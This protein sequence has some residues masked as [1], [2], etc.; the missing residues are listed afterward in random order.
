M[1]TALSIPRRVIAALAFL[2]LAP[3]GCNIAGPASFLVMGPEKVSKVFELNSEKRT[4]VFVDNR[5]SKLPNRAVHREVSETAER[6]LL[7]EGHLKTVISS[8]DAVAVADRD[9]YSK[10]IGI[11]ELG[12]AVNAEIVIFVAVDG[13]SL[14]PDGEA[15]KPQASA[16][17]KVMDVAQ[18]KRIFPTGADEWYG[19]EVNAPPKNIAVPKSTGERANENRLLAERFGRAIAYV[20]IDHEPREF[21]GRLDH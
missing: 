19:L 16:R 7:D 3:A 8:Q 9:R 5:A 1:A 10:P 4:V 17:I 14:T 12:E 18:K 21:T 13:F 11:V 2:A 20:F 15:F 6:V